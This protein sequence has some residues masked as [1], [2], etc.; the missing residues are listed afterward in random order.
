[1]STRGTLFESLERHPST[2]EISAASKAAQGIA[3][4]G[5][6]VLIFLLPHQAGAEAY[7]PR[8]RGA[9]G[10]LRAKEK[11]KDAIKPK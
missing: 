5:N 1:M 2:A 6:G 9:S 4:N 11:A 10:V 7:V 8:I 3:E